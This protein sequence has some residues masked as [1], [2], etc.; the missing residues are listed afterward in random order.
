MMSTYVHIRRYQYSDA[1]QV[2]QAIQESLAEVS[3][4]LPELNTSLTLEEVQSYIESQPS[5]RAE[6]KAYNF[7]IVDAYDSGI[8]GGCGLT[9]VNW[10]HRLAN[11]FYWVRSSRTGG[12]IASAATAQ[13]AQFGFETLELHRIEIVV[14]TRNPAS[15]RVAEKVG[16]KREGILRNRITLNDTVHDAFMYSLIPSDLEG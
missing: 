14:A 5:L 3:R 8:L 10:Q 2:F 15:I 4:W 12:G 11:L 13:L 9:R 16:A 6:R 1:V 7:A